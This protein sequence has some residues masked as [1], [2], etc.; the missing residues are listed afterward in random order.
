MEIQLPD[1]QIFKAKNIETAS[2]WQEVIEKMHEDLEKVYEEG[3]EN[4]I[5]KYGSTNPEEFFAVATVVYFDT[6][7]KLHK[8]APDVYR[9][10]NCFYQLNPHPWIYFPH[11]QP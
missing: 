8:G 4:I 7:E 11:P 3:R 1:G 6:P 5:R 2:Q 10:M 9:L